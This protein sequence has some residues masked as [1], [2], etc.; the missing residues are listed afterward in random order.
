[1]N[2]RMFEPL[3]SSKAGIIEAMVAHA[4]KALAKAEAEGDEFVAAIHR[5]AIGIGPAKAKALRESADTPW[6]GL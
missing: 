5:K 6:V 3:D 2:E 1:M 4:H